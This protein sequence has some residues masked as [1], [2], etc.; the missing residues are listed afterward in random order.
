MSKI[1]IS[2]VI[3]C[4]YSEKSIAPVLEQT[5]SELDKLEK[6]SYEFILVND[7]S[8]DGTFAEI[9]RLSQKYPFVTGIDLA[10]NF[11]QH[12]A[13]LAGMKYADGDY[14][15]GMDDDFQTHP[16]Q[17]Y[18]LIN[19]L[20][21]GYDIVYGKFPKR[22]H[23]FLRN[24]ESKLS[25]LSVRCLLD[26]PK[27]LKACPMYLIKKFVRDEIIKSESSFTNLQGLFLRT[28]SK[29]ANADIEHF[30][31]KYGKSGYNL[32]KLLHL[33][34][35][36]I[37]YSYKPIRLISSLGVFLAVAGLVYLLLSVILGSGF[38]HKVYSEIITFSGLILLA[39]GIVGEYVVRMF[40]TVTKQPQYVIRQMT[41]Y[42]NNEKS[43]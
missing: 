43:D 9:K 37:N 41:S 12:N 14:I 5:I 38:E 20:D 23:G 16:S 13:I 15:L 33:W 18:K 32:K 17:I 24:M 35:S 11:G 31:R 25:H 36:L 8:T 22:H 26:K 7:G 28:S 3:P 27:D 29:I 21:E 4:Y 42:N 10:K 40:M 2:V 1:K 39:V 19:K 30:D 6:Y 34:A